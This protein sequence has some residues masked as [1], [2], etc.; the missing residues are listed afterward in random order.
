M[1][2]RADELRPL[3][4]LV[5]IIGLTLIA[6]VGAGASRWLQII[7]AV[8]F[9]LSIFFYGYVYLYCLRNKPD[10]LRLERSS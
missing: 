4:V 3:A 5:G 2:T 1:T 10:A 7:V 9:V 6:V 8:L